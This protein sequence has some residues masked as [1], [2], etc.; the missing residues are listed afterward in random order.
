LNYEITEQTDQKD[1][2]KK[3]CTVHKMCCLILHNKFVWNIFSCQSILMNYAEEVH[4]N[5][6]ESIVIDQS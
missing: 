4:R 6:C 3:N 1:L 2:Q 5:V